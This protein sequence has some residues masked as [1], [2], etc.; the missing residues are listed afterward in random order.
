MIG[1]DTNILLRAATDDDK[2]LSPIARK[3]LAGLSPE[4]PG[5]VNSGVLAEFAWTL[6]TAYG[7]SRTEIANA[8][9]NM[10]R[11]R[12]YRICD[13][14]AVS[15]AIVSCHDERLDFADALIGQLNR[16]EGCETT[17]TFDERAARGSAFGAA[18]KA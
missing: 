8:I 7:Y 17:L 11:S 18:Y 10:L 13:R 6:R 12:S 4:R 5:V 3:I 14:G 1:L 16:A 9:E 15:C 2:V